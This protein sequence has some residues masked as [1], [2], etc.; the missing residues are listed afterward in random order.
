MDATFTSIA[1][2]LADKSMN[3]RRDHHRRDILRG[4]SRC[5]NG[6]SVT[7]QHVAIG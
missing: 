6:Y 7:L 1:C 2:A 4:K 5:R 3:V